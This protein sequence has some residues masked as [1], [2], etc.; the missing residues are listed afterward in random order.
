[1]LFYLHRRNIRKVK[2][3]DARDPHKSLDFG[4]GEAAGRSG[5]EKDSRTQYHRQMSMDMNLSS[6]YL[7][8]PGLQSSRESLNSLART[9]HQNEDPYR[10]VKEFGG[11]ET[12]SLRS[13]P[14]N[15][16]DGASLYNGSVKGGRNSQSFAP[17]VTG[18]APPRQNSVNR[19]VSPLPAPEPA[20][21]KPSNAPGTPNSAYSNPF[22]GG[23][24]PNTPV[25]G[26]TPYAENDSMPHVPELHEPP[27][28]EHKIARKPAAPHASEPSPADSGIA[29]GYGHES[30]EMMPQRTRTPSAEGGIGLGLGLNP[31]AEPQ[32]AEIHTMSPPHSHVGLATGSPP[33]EFQLPI[34]EEPSEHYED[35]VYADMPAEPRHPSDPHGQYPDDGHHHYE[36][37]ER[38]RNMQRQSHLYAHDGAQ[39]GAHG[40][41]SAPQQDSRRL[42]VGFRPLPPDDIMESE[43]PEYRANRIRSF[44]KEYFDD[45]KPLEPMPPLPQQYAAGHHSGYGQGADAGYYDNYDQGE[46]AYFDPDS[47]AF[48]MPYAQPVARRAM[49]PPPSGQRFPGPRG[50]G[51]R[52]P[53]RG[54]PGG[55]RNPSLGGMSLP[56]GPGPRPDSSVSNRHPGPRPGSAASGAWGRPRAGSTM[57]GGRFGGPRKP[58]PPPAALTTLPTPSK[59]KDDSFALLNAMDFAPP[60]SYADR[61]RGR[62]QSPFGERK[63]YKLNVPVHD[64]LVNAF[65]ELP[66]LPSP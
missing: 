36:E 46:A 20:Y 39:D 13:L 5:K 65:D 10:P 24:G 42:S 16:R 9:L 26:S 34:L 12:A 45:N 58:M 35:Y 49:T 6:P 2:D 61:A 47:N 59:L 23:T 21:M 54:P 43:D 66:A 7:L 14:H 4:F 1:M 3:E 48:V 27:A 51:P 57:S 32:H 31:L 18:I 19:S 41:L 25:I 55:P 22:A 8:P 56:G 64:H 28:A 29:V 17:S 52:G 63:E 62:S 30:F 33:P 37:E 60:E 44:Y 11:S 15:G 38:G 40:G 50:P 53:P